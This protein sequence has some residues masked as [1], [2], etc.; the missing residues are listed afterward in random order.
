MRIAA[1]T[2]GVP[3][4]ARLAAPV[5][6]TLFAL[7][8]CGSSAP[9]ATDSTSSRQ[10]AARAASVTPAVATPASAPAGE[11]TLVVYKTPS[12]GCCKGW[13][14]AMESSGFKVEVHDLDDLAA[15]KHAAGVPDELQ[16]CHTARIG[17]YVVEGHVHAEDIRRLLAERPDVAGIAAPGM[18]MGSPG[19]EGA[20]KDRYD[21]VTFGG[22]GRQTVFASH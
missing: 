14:K 12:C 19:M 3:R 8:A 4:H 17:G 21:V 11:P 15:T 13:V 16:S 1:I 20:Y 18:P 5:A 2:A 6:A 22:N 10:G 7:S 9:P